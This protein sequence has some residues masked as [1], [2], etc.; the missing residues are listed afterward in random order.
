MSGGPGGSLNDGLIG[1]FTKLGTGPGGGL[2]G[3]VGGEVG[4]G[5]G[6]RLDSGLGNRLVSGLGRRPGSV[7]VT[8]HRVR[9][10]QQTIGGSGDQQTGGG[11]NTPP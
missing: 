3:S 11:P 8:T 1:E 6:G 9:K 4:G 10:Y 7:Q 2:G 5:L